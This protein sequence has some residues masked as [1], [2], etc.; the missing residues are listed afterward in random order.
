LNGAELALHTRDLVIAD[1]EEAVALAGV[2]GGEK[3]SIL[4][5][6]DK[7]ILEIANFEPLGVRRTTIRHEIRTEA[8]T[9]FEKGVDPERCDLALSL[10]MQFFTELF[11]AMSVTEFHDNY[12][13]RMRGNE[14]EVSLDWL[15]KRLGKHIPNDV[16]AKKLELL[17]FEVG[18]EAGAA[19]CVEVSA[20]A[21]VGGDKMRVVAPTWRSTGDIS[22]PDDIIEEVA[23]I[24]GFENFEPTPINAVFEGPINQLDV[25]IDRKIREYLA[26]RCGMNEVF[27]YPWVSDEYIGAVLT[28]SEG[29]LEI[30]APPSPHE[31]FIRSSLLPNLCK[32]A[33]DNLRFYSDFAIFES[34]QVFFDRDYT[35]DYDPREKLPLQRRHIAGAYVGKYEEF[36]LI[37]RKTKGILEAMPGYV[38]IEPFRFSK[39]T[40]PA[41][42]DDVAWLNII[43][44]DELVG[45]LALLSKKASLDCGIRNSAVMLFELDLDLLKPL[46]SRTNK[47]TGIPEYPM[48]DYD[49]S[50]VF[51][52][53][54]TWAGII[55][56]VMSKKGP[57]SLLRDAFFVEEYKGRQVPG[58]KKSVTIRLLI[59]S[60][61][62]TLTS[63]EIEGCANAV[64]KRL[65]KAF[66]AEMR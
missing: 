6:T 51:D 34:A 18:V 22:I 11:P 26:F 61:K 41:W 20:G 32:A 9:R 66:G 21:R 45:N 63:E 49:I 3:D 5:D 56:V 62:K 31:R 23:R 54:V 37:F 30:T 12:P 27:T 44:G 15:E 40:K 38:H 60:L 39:D 65:K 17:G 4:P 43:T 1:E 25:D 50:M 36:D 28:D 13:Q 53:S 47:F 33:A 52:L 8:S 42:S 2:M 10:A 7:V 29:M 59:G 19:P 16:I 35:S 24:H 14:I 48:T 55:E 64:V 46:L 57:D 58:G